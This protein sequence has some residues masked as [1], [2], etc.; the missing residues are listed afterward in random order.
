ME[1]SD[2]HAHSTRWM[3]RHQVVLGLL[4][5]AIPVLSA[6]GWA[7]GWSRGHLLAEA[8]IPLLGLW[9]VGRYAPNPRLAMGA[10]GIGL[11]YISAVSV[12]VTGG[13]T[14]AHFG[15]FVAFGLVALY[16]DWWVFFAA[17]GFAVAHHAV[18]A[19]GDSTAL[20]DQPYQ[21]EDPV[22]WAVVH[23]TFVAIV[24]AVQAVG[25]YDVERSVGRRAEAEAAL[26]RADERRVTALTL[27]DDVVQ[28]LATAN[29]ARQLD[30]P[31]LGD[32]AID[33]ALTASRELVREL[34]AGSELDERVLRR[35]EAAQA[36]PTAAPRSSGLP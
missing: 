25:M 2:P 13:V 32:G 21:L 5:A 27:H 14:E 35:P 26:A 11:M 30:E 10:A 19:L 24:T 6:A 33:R 17:A 31:A 16:R 7:Q 29:Y 4:L 3:G 20:F 12:H 1:T 9:A 15:F 36:D 28:A 18:L 22:F 23:V 8:V 34:L